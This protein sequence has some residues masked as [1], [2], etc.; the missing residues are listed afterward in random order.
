M[1][2][3]LRV[4]VAEQVCIYLSTFPMGFQQDIRGSPA[5]TEY[6]RQ[7]PEDMTGELVLHQGHCSGPPKALSKEEITRGA[8]I[9]GQDKKAKEF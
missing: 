2:E 4:L 6:E 5:K 3:F 9:Q 8:E 7:K 1:T